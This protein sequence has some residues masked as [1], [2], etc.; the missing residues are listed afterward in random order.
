ME[1]DKETVDVMFERLQHTHV[2]CRLDQRINI[3]DLVGSQ[4]T[5]TNY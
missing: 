3:Q 2:Q 1:V 5:Q 4:L